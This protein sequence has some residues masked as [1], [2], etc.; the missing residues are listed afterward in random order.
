MEIQGPTVT[1]RKSGDAPIPTRK[2]KAKGSALDRMRKRGFIRVGYIADRMP[3]AYV[4]AK[5]GVVGFD[6]ELM[7]LLAFEL[8]LELEFFEIKVS[9]LAAQLRSGAVDIVASGSVMTTERLLEVSYTE[10]YTQATLAFLVEDYLRATFSSADEVRAL[11]S[12]TFGVPPIPYL[13]RY[14]KQHYPAAKLVPIDGVRPFLRGQ[15]PD[16][17]AVMYS[18]EAGSIWTLVYPDFSVAV[19]HPD[20]IRFPMAYPVGLGDERMVEFLNHWLELKR[21]DGTL[22]RLKTYWIE[23]REPEGRTRRWSVIRD[24]LGWVD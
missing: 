7:H 19:P 21:E 2:S 10:P 16:L 4:N 14:L 6:A 23:G 1:V 15:R 18:A 8:G 22:Q 5:S 12:P 3:Y 20:V 9:D 11:A 17:D 24:V 13:L